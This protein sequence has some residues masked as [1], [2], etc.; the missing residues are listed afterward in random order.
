MVL[1]F[2]YKDIPRSNG[3][4]AKSPSIPLTFFGN[5]SPYNFTALIDSGADVSAIPKG[6]AELLN[7]DFKNKKVEKTFGIGGVVPAVETI[8]GIELGK[9]HERYK[10]NIPIKIIL[11]G[12]DFP[13]LIGRAEFFDK[14]DITFKQSEKKI[15]L[16]SINSQRY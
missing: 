12:S 16:K 4:R 11:D 1:S 9:G 8:I 14:F 3:T 10:F 15:F 2:R 6:V 13:P 5:G 7:L